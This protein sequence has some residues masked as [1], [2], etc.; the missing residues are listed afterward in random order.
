MDIPQVNEQIPI[1]P[2]GSVRGMLSYILLVVLVL[3]PKIELLIFINV[4]Q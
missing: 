3:F 4:G 2:V 1:V